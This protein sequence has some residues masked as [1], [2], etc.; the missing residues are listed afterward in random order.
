MVTSL[1]EEQGIHSATKQVKALAILD[2]VATVGRNLK[3]GVR[4][5]VQC[6]SRDLIGLAAMVYEPLHHAQEK[7][8]IKLSSVCSCK[9]N[10]ARC[11]NIS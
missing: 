4:I 5:V 1:E 3:T 2:S 10:S 6:N 7:A 8:T 11:S 9:A